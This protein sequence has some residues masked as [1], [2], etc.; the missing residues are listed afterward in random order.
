VALGPVAFVIIC[1]LEPAA[2][3]FAA[4]GV[5]VDVD[6]T[7]CFEHPPSIRESSRNL[8]M[9]GIKLEL[10]VGCDWRFFGFVRMASSEF[11]M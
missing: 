4:G 10:S 9:S 5:A 8:E 6:E 1:G 3:K 7:V 11:P 2:V